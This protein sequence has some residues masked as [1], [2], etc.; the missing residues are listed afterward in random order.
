MVSRF[1]TS[2]P[3]GE[4]GPSASSE[5]QKRDPRATGLDFAAMW[6]EF[7]QRLPELREYAANYFSAR[8]DLVRAKVRHIIVRVVLMV[9]AVAIGITLLMAAAVL[10][11]MGA[12]GG[13]GALLGDRLWA[14]QL[15]IGV[16]MILTVV[17]AVWMTARGMNNSA[18]RK[19][20]VKYEQ[21]HSEQRS[22]FGRDVP[23]AAERRAE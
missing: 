3:V 5:Q 23:T 4:A 7:Q 17:L 9:F 22:R 18:R 12:A 15:I 16:G 21:R 1:P 10:A 13:I 2:D 14:G 6:A 8:A 19:A 11:V 20:Q